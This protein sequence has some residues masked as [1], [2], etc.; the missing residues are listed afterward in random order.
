[1]LF[2]YI[3]K[4]NI[5]TVW[6]LHDCWPFTGKCP[7]FT[8]VKCEKWKNGCYKCPQYKDYP[9]TLY[10][11][12]K[13]MW[14]LK[15]KWFTGVHNL[16]IVTPSEWL[17]KLVHESY[18]KEYPVKIINNGIDLNLFRPSE[19]NRTD[20]VKKIKKQ[21]YIVLGVAFD[22]GFRKGLD[23]FIKLTDILPTD[24]YQI[25]LVGTSSIIDKELPKS[26]ISVHRTQN[27]EELVELYTLADVFAMPTREE[28]FPTVN[29]EALACGNSCSDF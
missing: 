20:V 9:K 19:K 18:L 12:T 14:K 4:N 28:N 5:P 21:K 13:Q 29:L 1:M 11:N 2:K 8:I 24:K 27:Q 15:K 10:D 3:K 25:V 6:T 26:I 7:Y 23:I 22:W 17:A 16:T